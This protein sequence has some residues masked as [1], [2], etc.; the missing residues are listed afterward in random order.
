[1]INYTTLVCLQALSVFYNENIISI[2]IAD[3][4]QLII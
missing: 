3:K 4:N 1:M 2:K